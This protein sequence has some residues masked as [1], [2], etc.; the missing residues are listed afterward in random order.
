ML[1]GWGTAAHL[2]QLPVL[3]HRIIYIDELTLQDSSGRWP[4]SVVLEGTRRVLGWPCHHRDRVPRLRRE[5]AGHVPVL[6]GTVYLSPRASSARRSASR[7]V[8]HDVRAVR[9]VHGKEAH[10]Q[11]FMI[12]RCRSPALCGSP[13]RCRREL[14]LFVTVSGS[15]VPTSFRRP[16]TIPLMKRTGF[17]R[18]SPRRSRRSPPRRAADAALMEPPHS[19][20]RVP[21]R[22]Y[23]QITIWAILPRFSTISRCSRGAFGPSATT[24]PRA[25]ADL[26]RFGDVILAR[27]HLSCR[28]RWC[29]LPDPAIRAAVR[30][31]G[32]AFLPADRAAEKNHSRR[33]LLRMC[34]RRSRKAQ[35]TPRSGDGRA[36]RRHP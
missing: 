13:G 12:S 11:L 1:A 8:R 15:A 28:S 10:R 36:R 6:A 20:W 33:H 18:R 3:H 27:G 7:L 14:D 16:I 2:L 29:C 35:R 31:R 21:R 26:P 24:S 25:A 23:A 9:G 17:R 4:R 22:S 32:R 5:H 19:S 30:A 34:S